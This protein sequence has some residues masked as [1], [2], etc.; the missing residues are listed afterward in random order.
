MHIT[1]TNIDPTNP[2]HLAYAVA[3]LNELKKHATVAPLVLRWVTDVN[4]DFSELDVVS[5]G[6]PECP[7]TAVSSG[8]RE[9]MLAIYGKMTR[10]FLEVMLSRIEK[11]GSTTLEDAA[12][13]ANISLDTARAYLRNAG[14]TASAHKATFP[15]KPEWQHDMRCNVYTATHKAL[16]S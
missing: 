15:V 11:C 2:K 13:D 16:A 6:G 9:D 3:S 10:T 1:L 8:S 7:P 14:R 12:A 5:L 4:I